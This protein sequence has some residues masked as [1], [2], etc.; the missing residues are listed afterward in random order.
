MTD[1]TERE[2][3]EAWFL[4]VEEP[5]PSFLERDADDLYAQQRTHEA[6]EA[7]QARAA[8]PPAKPEREP[9]SVR[10][11]QVMTGTLK[12]AHTHPDAKAPSVPAP[13]GVQE[14]LAWAV[15][16]WHDEVRY[17]PIVNVNRR[18]LDDAWRQVI[19]HFGGDPEALLPLP[20]HDVLVQ[21]NPALFRKAAK[22]AAA[23]QAVPQGWK[24]VPCDPTNEMLKAA[25]AEWL[26]NGRHDAQF[27]LAQGFDNGL[28]RCWQLEL[29]R[30]THVYRAML[31]AAPPTPN[32]EAGEGAQAGGEA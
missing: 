8:L 20:R 4:D 11:Q 23:A 28:P 31:N 5:E 30:A 21:E 7:W 17:R 1:K 29:S 3:F 6:W 25:E 9:L 14:H 19:R 13:A 18:P 10:F 16:R 27:P 32:T 2:R 26:K 15:E 22:S 12:A 24:L